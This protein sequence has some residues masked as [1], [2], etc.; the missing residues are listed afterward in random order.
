MKK[1]ILILLVF[2]LGI[3]LYGSNDLIAAI[4][5][6]NMKTVEK[7]LERGAD[8]DFLNVDGK[9][10]LICAIL[11]ENEK[12]VQFLIEKGANI[13]FHA[14]GTLSPLQV[15]LLRQLPQIQNLLGGKA[16][17][18]SAAKEVDHL[19]QLMKENQTAEFLSTL[20]RSPQLANSLSSE[21]AT[22]LMYAAYWGKVA[23]TKA[24]LSHHARPN[25]T[26]SDGFTALH[27]AAAKGHIQTTKLLLQ[28]HA[29]V[30]LLNRK[31]MTPLML[32]A[33]NG[34][35]EIIRLL[36]S[37]G[38]KLN[39]KSQENLTFYDYGKEGLSR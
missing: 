27:L 31:G 20:S 19:V 21:G 7:L 4:E 28:S 16:V 24:L 29:D 17:S 32:A 5:D 12:M 37:H 10:P 23:Y 25:I 15:A 35:E 18:S 2:I 3:N 22:P 36:I 14:P 8:I 39:L 34:F 1:T 6:G 11:R 38:A 13:H 9:T 26:D 33:Q 30:N